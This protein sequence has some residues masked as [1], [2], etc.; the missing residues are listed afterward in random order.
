[1]L[2]ILLLNQLI[3]AMVIMVT[4]ATNNSSMATLTRLLDYEDDNETIGQLLLRIIDGV[5]D[6][7]KDEREDRILCDSELE[8]DLE[9]QRAVRSSLERDLEEEREARTEL[10]AS[11]NDLSS[12][13][14]SKL[15]IPSLNF[16]VKSNFEEE[17]KGQGFF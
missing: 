12:A 11:V 15:F 16:I 3:I 6:D 7:L 1:M 8:R 9:D 14:S 13:L 10:E 5:E 2:R 17:I 4:M